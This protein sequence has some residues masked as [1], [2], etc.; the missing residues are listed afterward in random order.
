MPLHK[1]V[2]GFL[3]IAIAIL[4]HSNH[5]QPRIASAMRL[6]SFG[7]VGGIADFEAVVG[8]IREDVDWHF[9]GETKCVIALKR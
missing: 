7:E 6:Q 5:F 8:V 1:T 4:K 2:D 9:L 3:S